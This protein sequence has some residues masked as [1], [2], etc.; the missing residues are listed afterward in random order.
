VINE[1]PDPVLT[2]VY[3]LKAVL[4]TPLECGDVLAGHR[5]VVPLAGGMFTGPE[6]NGNLLPGGSAGWQIVLPDGAALGKIRYTLRT[7]SGDIAKAVARLADL[8]MVHARRGRVGGTDPHQ[9]G[10]SHIHRLA[11]PSPRRRSGG[12][13][14]RRRQPVPTCAGM[15]PPPRPG[16]GKGSFLPRARPLHQR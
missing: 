5:R 10:T 3:R 2:P 16:G 1:L 8:G 11:R 13:R 15:S 9:R 14:M 7:D 12:H 6:L 4:G